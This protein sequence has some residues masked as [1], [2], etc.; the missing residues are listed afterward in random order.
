MSTNAD[1]GRFPEGFPEEKP[2]IKTS[3]GL[4]AG[5]ISACVDFPGKSWKHPGSA[6]PK[7]ETTPDPERKAF[8]KNLARR[9]WK[10]VGSQK[11]PGRSLEGSRKEKRKHEFDEWLVPR[12]PNT[13][14][15]CF[16]TWFSVSGLL[17]YFCYLCSLF[18]CGATSL[19]L[20]SLIPSGFRASTRIL[21]CSVSIPV[22]RQ[23]LSRPYFPF[24][25]QSSLCHS[26]ERR[27]RTVRLATSCCSECFV[28]SARSELRLPE[29]PRHLQKLSSRLD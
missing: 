20:R 29:C 5:H 2:D 3:V 13:H 24:L 15:L 6:L 18:L 4:P 14:Q 7:A 28:P 23:A 26:T 11:I 10:N 9:F 16:L 17:L 27:M 19:F 22:K 12:S 25:P 8:L 21:V 1:S